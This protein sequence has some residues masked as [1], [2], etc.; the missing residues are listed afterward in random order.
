MG[1]VFGSN[2]VKRKPCCDA[3]D[4]SNS[5]GSNRVQ[6]VSAN[7]VCGVYRSGL[8]KTVPQIIPEEMALVTGLS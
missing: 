6:E 1:G 3:A 2:Q 4:S 7:K 5:F 8:S